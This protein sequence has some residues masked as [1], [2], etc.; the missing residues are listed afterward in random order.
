MRRSEAE[1]EVAARMIHDLRVTVAVLAASREQVERIA[2]QAGPWA[3]LVFIHP[4]IALNELRKCRAESAR[5]GESVKHLVPPAGRSRSF[6]LNLAVRAA[7]TPWVLLIDESAAL[8]AE[9]LAQIR[10]ALH[11]WPQA[12]QADVAFRTD[13]L[14]TLLNRRLIFE[15]G[16]FDERIPAGPWDLEDWRLRMSSWVGVD[17]D[18]V[19]KDRYCDIPTPLCTIP[20]IGLADGAIPSMPD[21]VLARVAE[22]LFW[23]K[24]KVDHVS[25]FVVS[26]LHRSGRPVR[27]RATRTTDDYYP[28]DR[29]DYGDPVYGR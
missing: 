7:V 10:I 19:Q 17:L 13:M 23:A 20:L 4:G 1:L 5:W 9:W 28:L 11:R 24:W 3:T 29:Q 25:G 2:R 12:L 14:A 18:R 22:R 27:V 6:Y 21:P 8:P 16:W 26:N 15:M